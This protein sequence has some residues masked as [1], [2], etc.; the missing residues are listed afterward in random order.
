MY[1][2]ALEHLTHISQV[3]HHSHYLFLQKILLDPETDMQHVA[4][5]RGF[6]FITSPCRKFPLAGRSVGSDMNII[7]DIIYRYPAEDVPSVGISH[8]PMK[9]SS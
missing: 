5:S 3:Q 1:S 7:L 9:F 8:L 4:H 6:S 2:L